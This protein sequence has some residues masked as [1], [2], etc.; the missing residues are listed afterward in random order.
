MNVVLASPKPRMSVAQFL[1]WEPGDGQRWQL[2]DGVPEAMAPTIRT[3]GALQNEIG[4]LIGNYLLASDSDGSVC[5]NPGV[6]PRVNAA[7]NFRI[8][9]VAVVRGGYIDEER[10]LTAPLIAI[11]ILS[12]SNER[13][14][15]ANVWSYTSIP[16]VAE[17][18][19]FYTDAIG[20]E[21]LRRQPDGSWPAD[22][23]LVTEGEIVLDSI[24]LRLPIAACYRTTRL[25]P[26][27]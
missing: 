6:Q 10:L 17:I 15:R 20:A 11:E 7:Y 12:E 18:V 23:D 19:V 25:A 27:G 4:R 26:P 2:V 24:G 13:E 8:P 1:Q 3:H 21:V 14:T 9:D 5:A 16:S 22:P